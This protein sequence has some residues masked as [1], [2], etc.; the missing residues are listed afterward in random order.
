MRILMYVAIAKAILA[1]LGITTYLVYK[2]FFM[3][4]ASEEEETSE[5]EI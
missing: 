4:K 2:Q 3:T 1:V 5:E